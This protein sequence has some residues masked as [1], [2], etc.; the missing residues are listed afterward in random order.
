MATIYYKGLTGKLDSVT[1]ALTV[2]IDQ[3]ITAIAADEGL[4]TEYYT[5]SKQGEPDKN[6][7]IYGDS[8]TTLST[9]GFVDGD[10]VICTTNQYGSKQERQIEK[11]EIAAVKRA[12]TGR[13]ST[14]D[15][16]KLPNPYNGNSADPDDGDAG[17]LVQGRPWS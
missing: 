11:L 12:A 16:N 10:T 6:S 8:S 2:T 4:P 13:T 1:V 7:L 15:I 5:I 9:M 14:Y 3:L 17:P